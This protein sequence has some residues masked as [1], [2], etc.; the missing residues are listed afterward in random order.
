VGADLFNA[1]GQ[2]DGHTDT[3]TAK[4]N[5]AFLTFA[6]APKNSENKSY[7]KER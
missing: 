2:T 5:F 6:N 4:P 7:K 1:D 3:D